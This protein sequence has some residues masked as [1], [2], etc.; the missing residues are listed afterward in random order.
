MRGNEYEL[1]LVD[2]AG[3]VRNRVNATILHIVVF[4]IYK[5]VIFMGHN[6]SFYKQQHCYVSLKT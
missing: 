3:Q 5:S 2:T 6:K 1:F 4:Y